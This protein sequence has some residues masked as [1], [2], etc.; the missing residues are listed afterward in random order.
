MQAFF[1]DPYHV[2]EVVS[3]IVIV[4][5]LIADLLLVIKRPH[6]PSMKEATLWVCFYVT[7]ALIFAG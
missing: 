7:L 5:I 2:F 1:Q 6:T 4:L 3:G